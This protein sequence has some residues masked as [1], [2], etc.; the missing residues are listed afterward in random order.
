MPVAFRDYYVSFVR[1][2]TLESAAEKLRRAAGNENDPRFNIVD[3]IHKLQRSPG[4][5]EFEIRFF[6]Q[7]PGQDFAFVSFEPDA[8]LN[9]DAEVWRLARL[10]EPESRFIVA[11]E[12]GHLVFHD[13]HAKAF[14]ENT[15]VKS[16]FGTK[17][18]SA[19]WQANTFAAY[20]LVPSKLVRSLGSTGEIVRVCGAPRAI[21]EARFQAVTATDAKKSLLNNDYCTQCGDMVGPHGHHVCG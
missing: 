16:W 1:E 11:H 8:V 13:N 7:K 15:E 2:E 18:F 3:F 9:V 12:L 17:E 4:F 20:F 5:R 19:E 21:A 14:S 10:G 6:G